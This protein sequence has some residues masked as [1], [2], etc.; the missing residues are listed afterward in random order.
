MN[1]IMPTAMVTMHQD[2]EQV[3]NSAR[4]A[5]RG[6]RVWKALKTF[7]D[8]TANAKAILAVATNSLEN[9][10]Q[11]DPKLVQVSA[12]KFLESRTRNH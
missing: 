4:T 7:P 10:T 1:V 3:A 12:S 8:A 11:L 2:A 6:V 9:N 5:K